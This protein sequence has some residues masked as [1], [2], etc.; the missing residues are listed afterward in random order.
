MPVDCKLLIKLA[1]AVVASNSVKRTVS[2][3]ER[4]SLAT[5]VGSVDVE[6]YVGSASSTSS[7]APLASLIMNT[8]PSRLTFAIRAIELFGR[9]TWGN[10]ELVVIEGQG[11]DELEMGALEV[12]IKQLCDERIKYHRVQDAGVNRLSL[13]ELRNMAVSFCSS[14]SEYIA[15]WDD[16]DLHHPRRVQIQIEQI[17]IHNG[18]ACLLKRLTGAWPRRD[19]YFVTAERRT[20]WEGSVVCRRKCFPHYRPLDRGEDTPAMQDM[21]RTC[22]VLLIDAPSLYFYTIHG[23]NTSKERHFRNIWRNRSA[24]IDAI[25]MAEDIE[26]HF[27]FKISL[28]QPHATVEGLTRLFLCKDCFPRRADSV[29]KLSG[30]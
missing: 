18:D 5:D 22:H 29:Q 30:K 8:S 15:V 14:E 21:L 4:N 1:L 6:R 27:A 10:M 3:W 23:Q 19:A 28:G 12:H 7:S 24:R 11:T 13:G 25:S 16:D 17:L 20:G 9:Q 26:S 2:E